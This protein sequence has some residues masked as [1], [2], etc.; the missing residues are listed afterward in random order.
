[1]YPE[2]DAFL[3]KQSEKIENSTVFEYSEICSSEIFKK[4]VKEA[5]KDEITYVHGYVG[6]F[7]W[8]WN[9]D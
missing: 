9:I 6:R 5:V 2:F 8:T 3:E 7:P 4:R 1:M